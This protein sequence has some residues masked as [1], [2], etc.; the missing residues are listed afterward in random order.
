LSASFFAFAESLWPKVQ[1]TK[2]YSQYTNTAGVIVA[3]SKQQ[4]SGW[5][6][7]TT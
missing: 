5:S 3:W 4:S 2:Y 7:L 6:L 1:Y